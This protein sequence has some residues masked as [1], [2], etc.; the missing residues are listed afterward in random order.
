MAGGYSSEEVLKRGLSGPTPWIS[1]KNPGESIEVAFVIDP[2]DPDYGAVFWPRHGWSPKEKRYLPCG[3]LADRDAPCPLCEKG[4][5]QDW[6]VSMTVFDVQAGMRRY[7]DSFPAVWFQDLK[8]VWGKLKEKG[9]DPFKL[10][11]DITRQGEGSST[12]RIITPLAVMS[13]ELIE[14]V[15]QLKP[16][17]PHEMVKGMGSPKEYVGEPE[18]DIPLPEDPWG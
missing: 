9:A 17:A 2:N 7:L 18:D 5:K 15:S 13:D 10:I 12:R 1:L 11:Y 3:K 4:E 6:R 8:H 14:T 16:F